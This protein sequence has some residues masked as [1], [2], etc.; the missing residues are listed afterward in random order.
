MSA[1]RRQR[2]AWTRAVKRE[3]DQSARLRR[4]P[5]RWAKRQAKWAKENL[6]PPWIGGGWSDEDLKEIARWMHGNGYVI[7]EKP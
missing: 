1:F 4:E 5:R 6:S 3:A 2:R 7:K